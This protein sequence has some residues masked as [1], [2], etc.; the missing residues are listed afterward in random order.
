MNYGVIFVEGKVG[1]SPIGLKSTCN[2]KGSLVFFVIE[3]NEVSH[4]DPVD[5]D[6]SYK[7]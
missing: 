6:L 7:M 3:H 4:R 5:V 2:F 1:F